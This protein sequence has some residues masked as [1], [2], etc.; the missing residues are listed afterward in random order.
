MAIVSFQLGAPF[1]VNGI[2]L[3]IVLEVLLPSEGVVSVCSVACGVVLFEGE[4]TSDELG[5]PVL[6][7]DGGAAEGE[8]WLVDEST[9]LIISSLTVTVDFPAPKKPPS[10]QLSR[11]PKIASLSVASTSFLSLT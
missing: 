1:W 8:V 11:C 3:A 2:F 4:G 9:S 6:A 5:C 10:C 7:C